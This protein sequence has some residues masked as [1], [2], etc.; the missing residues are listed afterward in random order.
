MPLKIH[1]VKDGVL[2]DYS[3][4]ISSEEILQ[5]NKIVYSTPE[6]DHLRS[7]IAEFIGASRG[8]VTERDVRLVAA[9]DASAALSN[10]RIVV[11][12]VA[13]DE[14]ILS[15]FERYRDAS[16]K[17]TWRIEIF[18]TLKD[19]VTWNNQQGIQVLD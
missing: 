12:L 19:A 5:S 6:F 14:D 3:G 17:T 4:E 10:P 2:W 18:R 11:A 16:L 7:E 1:W 8:D 9:V 15:L 13:D